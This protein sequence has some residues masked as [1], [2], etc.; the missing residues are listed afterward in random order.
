M[1]IR[2]SLIGEGR[3]RIAVRYL[4]FARNGSIAMPVSVALV[5]SG[6]GAKGEFQVGFLEALDEARLDL[7]FCLFTGVSVGALNATCL[8]QYPD[9]S[10]GVRSLRAV[11]DGIEHND[12]VYKSLIPGSPEGLLNRIRLLLALP[13]LL[14]RPSLYDAAPLRKLIEASVAWDRLADSARHGCVWAVGVTSLTDG[15]YYLISN[16]ERFVRVGQERYKGALA[17]TLEQGRPGSI[18]D[19]VVD[20]VLAS[21]SMPTMFPPVEVGGHLL[22][23]GGLRDVT[24][25][26]AP[27]LAARHEICRP[28][29]ILVV[30]ASPRETPP[31]DGP[32]PP[33]ITDIASRGTEIMVNEIIRND[34]E[35]AEAL[36]ELARSSPT[37]PPLR[38]PI[39]VVWPDTTFGL[40]ALNFGQVSLRR[41][42]REHGR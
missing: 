42:L 12:Q 6:G 15:Q 4:P 34:V 14:K 33:R 16:D 18:P 17:L 24:P 39:V 20:F 28:E 41:R 8:A 3:T 2:K 13:K 35:V 9:F 31:W 36:N 1:A 19:H 37:G 22:V 10:E 21:A 7:Q 30:N 38:L 11:W 23:D 40:E 26:S 32:R 27:F 29:L 5:L 25:L